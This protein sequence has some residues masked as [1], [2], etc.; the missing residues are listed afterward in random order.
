MLG[1]V[2]TLIIETGAVFK[3]LKFKH[4]TCLVG[5]EYFIE[6]IC[7]ENCKTN[8]ELLTLIIY[9]YF[10]STLYSDTVKSVTSCSWLISELTD[11]FERLHECT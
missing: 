10:G 3:M 8:T 6:F 1:N 11:T 7:C 2:R 9:N 4:R 5:Q